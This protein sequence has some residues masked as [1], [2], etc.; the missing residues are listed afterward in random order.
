MCER[1][2]KQCKERKAQRRG[3]NHFGGE[4][5]VYEDAVIGVQGILDCCDAVKEIV[6]F[7]FG[8]EGI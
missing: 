1:K 3:N 8:G 6:M 2:R 4:D 5:P 7:D